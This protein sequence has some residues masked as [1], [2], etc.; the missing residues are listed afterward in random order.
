MNAT[1]ADL[2]ENPTWVFDGDVLRLIVLVSSAC[3]ERGG[4]WL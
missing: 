2:D 3:S 1:R 4:N